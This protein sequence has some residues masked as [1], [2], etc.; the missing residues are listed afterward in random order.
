MTQKIV[1]ELRRRIQ[2]TYNI[3]RNRERYDAD[4]FVE[5]KALRNKLISFKNLNYKASKGE[6]ILPY[7]FEKEVKGECSKFDKIVKELTGYGMPSA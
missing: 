1:N 5:F 2:G 6:I 3:N 7:N 4:K